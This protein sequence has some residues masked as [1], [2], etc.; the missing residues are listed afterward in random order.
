MVTSFSWVMIACTT[1]HF[2]S[3]KAS[4]CPFRAE[5]EMMQAVQWEHADSQQQ[6]EVV[7]NL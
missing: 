3:A 4:L 7:Q 6:G 1:E 2:A 5:G